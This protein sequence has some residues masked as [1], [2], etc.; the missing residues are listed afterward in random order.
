MAITLAS[1]VLGDAEITDSIG[2]GDV[3]SAARLWVRYWPTALTAARQYVEPAEVPGLAAEALIGTIAAIA[4][5]RGPREDVEE[6]VTSAV[7]ELGEGDDQTPDP[8]NAAGHPDVFVSAAMTR[9]FAELDEA[10]QDSLRTI[11]ADQALDDD[12]ARALTV[13][14]HYYLA[15]HADNAIS[16]ACRRPHIALMSVAEGSTKNMSA[17]AWVHLSTCAWCTE[18]FHEIASSNTAL[19]ALIDPAV[20]HPVASAPIAPVA[21]V[22]AATEAVEPWAAEPDDTEVAALAAVPA[23]LEVT[24][25]VPF[26]PWASEATATDD[27][28]EVAAVGVASAAGARKRGRRRRL[29]ALAAVTAAAV[30]VVAVVLSGGDDGTTPASAGTTPSATADDPTLPPSIGGPE[31]P[32]T[33]PTTPAATTEAPTPTA[34]PTDAAT[35]DATTAAAKPTKKSTPTKKPTT[36]PSSTPRPS[37]PPTTAEPT[38]TPTPTPTTTPK[39]CN[40]LQ[41]LLGLC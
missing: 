19:G 1:D 11:A 35:A 40:A 4:I 25:P 5:G 22:A 17:E 10:T 15:E 32:E 24:T 29:V 37:D 8:G 21:G 36:K 28:T 13:L 7:R 33:A 38:P 31:A 26:E 34:T 3:G 20:L 23:A 9:S 16:T 14:Q 2:A 6:F 30:A 12:H 41:K 39:P 27:T 18:A